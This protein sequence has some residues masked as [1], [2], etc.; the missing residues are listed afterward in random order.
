VVTMTCH[1]VLHE[2]L[3]Q[4]LERTEDVW[5]DLRG[6]RLFITGGTGFFGCWLLESFVW[7]CDR[8]NL[9]ASTTVLSRDPERFR[10]VAP[11]LA[12]HPA[13]Q[14]HRGDVRSFDYPPG[15]FTH[16][17]HAAADARASAILEA[18]LPMFETIVGGT[19]RVLEFAVSCRARKFLL[20][21]SGAVYGKQ[22]PEVPRLAEDFPGAPNVTEITAAYG[23]GKRAAEILATIYHEKHAL[24]VKIARCFAFIGPYLPL[25]AHFAIGNF[26]R[27]GLRGGPIRVAGDGTAC[28]TYQYAADLVVWL[29]HILVRGRNCYPYNV[30]SEDEVT[31][32]SLAKTVARSFDPPMIVEI[33]GQVVPGRPSDRY[34]PSV[35]R[36]QQE[37][38]LSQTVGLQQAIEKTRRWHCA[39]ANHT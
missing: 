1:N 11:D 32:A 4:I 21:S 19:R 28:R 30:G 5:A 33:A 20:V 16:V 23:E 24:D 15:E 37:L 25:D 38:G 36:A 6:A 29:W 34:V 14:F 26:L 39:A 3:D 7:A 2:D 31:I 9:G 10:G 12:A 17:V 35:K 18:P 13:I 8:L 22:P 27:D